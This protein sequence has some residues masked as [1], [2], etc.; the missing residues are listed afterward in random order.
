MDTSAFPARPAQR[1]FANANSYLAAH[2]QEMAGLSITR[3]WRCS[4]SVG[5]W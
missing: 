5:E 3:R 4:T 2:R 1:N